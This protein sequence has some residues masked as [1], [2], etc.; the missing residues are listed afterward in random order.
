MLVP[1]LQKL[2]H[3]FALRVVSDGAA[4]A[5]IGFMSRPIEDDTMNARHGIEDLA[6]LHERLKTDATRLRDEAIADFISGADVA[7]RAAARR[8]VRA[9][10]RLAAR[11]RQHARQRAAAQW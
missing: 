1:V 7:L 8:G 4:A 2:Q 5:Y 10:N 11:L 9:A 6:A 3:R